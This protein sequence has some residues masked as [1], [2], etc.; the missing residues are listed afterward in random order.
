MLRD[1]Y[2][3]I[4]LTDDHTFILSRYTELTADQKLLVRQ[5]NLELA[6]Q[7][8]PRGRLGRFITPWSG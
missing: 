6:S 7:P 5:S 2:L 8:A 1:P 4:N 3:L